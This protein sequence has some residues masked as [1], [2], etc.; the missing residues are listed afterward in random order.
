[1]RDLPPAGRT[2]LITGAAGFTGRGIA[3]ALAA[4]GAAIAVNDIDAESAEAF[5]QELRAAGTAA[6]AAP[7][8]VT[9]HESV[10]AGVSIVQTALAPIDILVNNVG[11]PRTPNKHVD[12]A[13]SDPADWRPWI[14][15]NIYGSLYCLRAV[16][17]GMCER[18]W[19]R[20]IQISSS[21]AARGLP[22][23]ESLLGGS[24]AGIEGT[25]RS[26]AMEVVE[27]G[28]TV[29]TVALGLLANA[30]TH[31][32]QEIVAATLATVPLGRF[33]KPEEV[34]AAVAYLAS[35]EAACVTAQVIH[36]NGGAYHGR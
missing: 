32:H 25:L 15:I 36:L 35:E 19:G 11:M 31:A 29:N 14:D 27:R 17:A 13:A 18:G 28:V 4:A 24:K 9:N 12:F 21:M 26:V 3:R 34:G 20:V 6:C 2:A 5:A 33:V 30:T 22:N 10:A 1:V 23:R 8:D 7:F 16:L